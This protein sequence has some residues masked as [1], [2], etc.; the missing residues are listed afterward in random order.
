MT[1]ISAL[2]AGSFE[3]R[4]SES[5]FLRIDVGQPAM[6]IGGF[7]VD[8]VEEGAL[9]RRGQR[10]PPAGAHFDLVDRPDRGHLGRG[11]HEEHLVGDVK[12][13]AR[14]DLLGD[15]KAQVARQRDD[16]VAGDAAENRRAEGRRVQR[17]IAHDKD[18][19]AAP[20]A[21]MAGDVEHDPFRI[22][23]GERLHLDESRVRVVRRA[24]CH[25]RQRIGRH[26]SPGA[27]LDVH[28][29]FDRVLAE[30]GAPVPHHDGGVDG[31]VDRVDAERLVPAI[32]ERADIAGLHLVGADRFEHRLH[33]A[34]QIEGIL[35]PVNLGRV[36]QAQHMG[37]ET[38]AGR[39]LRCRVA[40][41]A[42]EHAAP[43]V[44]DVRRDVN[45]RVLPVHERAVHP[46]LAGP[47]KSHT[48]LLRVILQHLVNG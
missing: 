25:G 33:P 21:D 11:P 34:V 32:D 22:A 15:R 16:R 3:R 30:V 7:P 42:L 39:A 27:D 47:R 48:A 5:R 31:V 9:D 13:L 38:E 29:F 37:I 1:C 35:H 10:T 43:V 28:A 8:D 2:E 45:R 19:L 24:L 12:R 14:Q 40:P 23:V 6:R 4:L 26:P 18:I 46:D 17:A 41:R 20:L 36:L 44:D